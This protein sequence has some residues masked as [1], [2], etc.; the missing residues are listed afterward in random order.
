MRSI[1]DIGWSLLCG[2]LVVVAG[3]CTRTTESERPEQAPEQAKAA[4][5]APAEAAGADET[6]APA[7]GNRLANDSAANGAA[8]PANGAAATPA[9]EREAEGPGRPSAP[10][11]EGAPPTAGA[12]S[13]N[14]TPAGPDAR[15][16]AREIAPSA[17]AAPLTHVITVP[18]GTSLPLV[19][20]SAV[21]SDS[22]Q[23]EDPVTARLASNVDVEGMAAIPEGA[24][25]RG[26]VSD[27]RRSG[28][29]K[30]VARLGIRFHTLVIG[31]QSYDIQTASL[32]RQAK[33]TVKKDTQ[34]V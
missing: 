8:A 20:T 4:R 9:P 24:V 28:R 6:F 15:G 34:K 32:S 13:P 26:T 3:A 31:E 23:V 10:D 14:A 21:A 18:E 16:N 7:A 12:D 25:V 27:V 2:G 29:V 30:G 11:A 5:P 19:L 22:S 17:P 33:G 1:R